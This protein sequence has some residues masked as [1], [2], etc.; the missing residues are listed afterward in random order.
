MQ[1]FAI[2]VKLESDATSQPVSSAAAEMS[3]SR[4]VSRSSEALGTGDFEQPF[5]PVVGSLADIPVC[6]SM[7][8]W[9]IASI[10]QIYSRT[11][12]KI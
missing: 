3:A 8:I 1:L 5:K 9:I 6:G 4:N 11:K 7:V 12:E 2:V 10:V